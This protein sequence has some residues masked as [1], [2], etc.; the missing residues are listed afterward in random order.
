MTLRVMQS[1]HI[2]ALFITT[3]S[4]NIEA[5]KADK[6]IRETGECVVLD[7]DGTVAYD[8][9]LT[10]IRTRGNAS[11]YYAK[12]S[13]QVKLEKPASLFGMN[14]DRKWVLLANYVDKSLLR[15]T[16]AY[17]IAR[18]AD[19]YSFVPGSQPVDLYLNHQYYGSFL[20]TEKCEIDPD[21]LDID[22]LE[23][24]TEDMNPQPL[25]TYPAF[26]DRLYALKSRKGSVLNK[27][28][29]DITGGYLVLANSRVYYAWEKSG[30]VTSRGQS[31]TLD[32]PKYASPGQVEY[33][34]ALFQRIENALFSKDGI[35]PETQSHWS[36]LVD[37]KTF[38]HRYLLSEV[39]ADYDG[40]K[41]YFYKDTDSKDPT[42]Y[43][44]PVWDQDCIFGANSRYN[45]AASFY[46]CN[47]KSLAYLWFPQAM[48]LE[49][50]RQQAMQTYRDVYAPALR[51]LLGEEKDPRGILLS[52]DEYAREIA[53]SAEMD[54]IRWPIS[55]NRG[56]NFN[57]H[58]GSTP[59]ANVEYLRNFIQRRMEFL[60]KQWSGKPEG[61]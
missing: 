23:E 9:A 3:V 8:G 24:R 27:E 7:G 16:L 19:V 21:R 31:F 49:D 35:D 46:I 4:G 36:E 50:F 12:K 10:Y 37:A 22:D 15:N 47:D 18:Y 11:F 6:T 14:S 52:L 48:K 32:E 29:E 44:G 43:C 26:G 51:I 59:K 56:T 25:D 30:F 55:K 60:D 45:K 58:T 1:E 17:G 41:P 34:A 13:F 20:L 40:Q 2:P 28:P 57:T 61:R 54:N 39:T 5:L 53:A 42:V 33:V 38:V